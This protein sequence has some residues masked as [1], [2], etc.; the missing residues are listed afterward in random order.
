MI[1]LQENKGEDTYISEISFLRGHGIK[2][3]GKK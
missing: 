3:K 2:I 1:S